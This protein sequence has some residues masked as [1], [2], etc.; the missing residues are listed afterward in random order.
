MVVS[1]LDFVVTSSECRE[2]IGDTRENGST[3]DCEERSFDVSFEPLLNTRFER[4]IR[5]PRPSS[6]ES[7]NRLYCSHEAT[8]AARAKVPFGSFANSLLNVSL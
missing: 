3:S 4:D 5:L 1:D 8:S 7:V 2:R 6:F